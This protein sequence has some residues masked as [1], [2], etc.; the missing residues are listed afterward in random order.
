M[1]VKKK[2][3]GK[4]WIWRCH[5]DISKP[6][7][8]VWRFLKKFVVD[9]DAAVFSAPSFAQTLPI[10][11]YLITPSIDPLSEKNRELDQ[12]TIESVLTKYGLVS[13]KPMIVQISRFDRL[14][15]PVGVIEAFKMVRKSLDCQLV[16]A[17]GTADDD[18]ES[19]VVLEEV[20][21][22]LQNQLDKYREDDFV[23]LFLVLL[24]VF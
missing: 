3:A 15:D 12:R 6:H 24:G 7:T 22:L 17:G 20:R 1:I 16:L 19:G 9:Y 4:K 11:Q 14:K 2:E 23:Q 13:D 21:K 8:R 10:P 18:P 5:I